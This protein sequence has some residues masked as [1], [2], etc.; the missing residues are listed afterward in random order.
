[1][2]VLYIGFFV[3]L[4]FITPVFAQEPRPQQE[5]VYYQK[6]DGVYREVWNFP[7]YRC[8]PDCKLTIALDKQPRSELDEENPHYQLGETVKI[9]I[10]FSF[11]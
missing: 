7:D 4:L 1:M 11:L 5:G 6:Q 2:K 8:Q 10:Q 9:L 3:F